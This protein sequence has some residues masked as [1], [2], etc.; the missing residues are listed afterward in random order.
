MIIYNIRME[1][2]LNVMEF[3]PLEDKYRF[4]TSAFLAVTLFAALV[5]LA[6]H[7]LARLSRFFIRKIFNNEGRWYRAFH[8]NNIFAA[9]GFLLAGIIA[10]S[11]VPLVFPQEYPKLLVLVTK[12]VHIYN[13][14]FMLV[15]LNSLLD[16][17]VFF[18][19]R[20]PNIPVRGTAQFVKIALNTGGVLLIVAVYLDKKPIVLIS[21]LGITASVLALVFKDTIL[22]LAATY[23][24]SF[25][26]MAKVGDWI[27]VPKHGADGY[28]T[29]ISLITVRV[30][31]WDNTY[32]TLPTNDLIA[33][34]FKNWSGMY[35]SGGRR[36]KRAIYIDMHTVQF[37]TPEMLEALRSVELIKNYIAKKEQELEAYNSRH[38]LKENIINGRHLTNLGTF[39]AYCEE[40][41]KTRPYINSAKF[42]TMVRQLDPDENGLPLEVYCFTNTT[43]WVDY[44]RYQS[45]IFD[46]F[47]S[48]MPLFGLKPFQNPGGG[49][50]QKLI[51]AREGEK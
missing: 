51:I 22:N 45:D 10:A 9:T 41:L 29:D 28:I 43:D 49:D 37:L 2:I 50:I 3:I 39:R 7:L 11:M 23:Q 36:I 12:L 15:T 40:Y 44:E 35:E 4:L 48:A 31:N 30:Q 21:A 33:S 47:L 1:L 8:E 42:T 13:I 46:H 26:K 38:N 16:I 14:I 32:V 18:H 27:E 25:N 34:S 20:N 17:I 24:L 5:F 19:A 6:G